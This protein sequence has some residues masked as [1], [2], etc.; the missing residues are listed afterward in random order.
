M[1]KKNI[2]IILLLLF[3]LLPIF[4]IYAQSS[5]AGFIPG[6]IWY[7]KDPFEEGDQIKI[8][9]LVFN[10]DDRE[11]SG[12]V[13]FF[14]NN[15]FF[16]KKDFTASP[17]DVKDVSISWT[18]TAGDHVIFAKIENAKFLVSGGQ[19]E[20]VYLAENETTKSSRTVNK[21]VIVNTTDTNN[22]SSTGSSIPGLSSIQNVGNIVANSTPDYVA[23][24][25]VLGAST[26]EN[27]RQNI[28]NALG[29]NK[30]DT[31][32]EINTLNSAKTTLKNGVKPNTSSSIQKPFDYVKLFFLY[33][34]EAIFKY[35]LVFYGLLLIILVVILRYI[36]N[37]IF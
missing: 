18:A 24:P 29:K 20:E 1:T 12:T 5:N 37:L 28:S 31:Q 23:K 27:F 7:S 30:A 17:K 19:Y 4:K 15:V 2:G 16:A 34:F 33:I 22:T 9:T 35:K 13:V 26:V 11:L 3:S 36:W 25:M 21:K 14:D 10:P 8:Y 6:N 32:K